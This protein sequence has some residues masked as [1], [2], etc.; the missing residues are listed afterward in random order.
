M[1]KKRKKHKPELDDESCID[2]EDDEFELDPIDYYDIPEVWKTEMFREARKL[3]KKRKI[4][5]YVI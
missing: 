4:E 1:V 2:E 5:T 3:A